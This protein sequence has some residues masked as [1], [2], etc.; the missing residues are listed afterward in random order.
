MVKCLSNMVKLWSNQ[1]AFTCGEAEEGDEGGIEGV[2]VVRGL[3]AEVVDAHYGV[4]HAGLVTLLQAKQASQAR[5]A[6]YTRQTRQCRQAIIRSD[7]PG[8]LD[9]PACQLVKWR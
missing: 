7:K 6:R 2:E 5:Q 8:R 4:C 1:I 3:V 9:R